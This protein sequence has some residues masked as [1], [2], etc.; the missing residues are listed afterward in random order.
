[1]TILMDDQSVAQRI[2]DH[3]EHRTTDLGQSVWR[4]PVANYRSEQRMTAEVELAFRRTPTPFC[5]SAALPDVGCYVA[6]DAAGTP[7]LVVR[8]R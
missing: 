2:L 7:L 3:I 5:P 1:M 6:R 4:E 8:A